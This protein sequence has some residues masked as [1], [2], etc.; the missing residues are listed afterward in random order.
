MS[1]RNIEL[2]TRCY[3]DIYALLPPSNETYYIDMKEIVRS[4]VIFNLFLTRFNDFIK[5]ITQMSKRSSMRPIKMLINDWQDRATCNLP[6]RLIRRLILTMI[7]VRYYR[8]RAPNQVI[9]MRILLT[10]KILLDGGLTSGDCL[11][12]RKLGSYADW[13]CDV[14]L[15]ENEKMSWRSV[16]FLLAMTSWLLTRNL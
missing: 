16:H 4:Q 9:W 11:T 5:L 12:S 6:Q 13:P 15:L 7:R 1:D 10:C 14:I 2:Y 8:I 3:I